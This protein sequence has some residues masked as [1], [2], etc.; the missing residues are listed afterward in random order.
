MAR[1]KNKINKNRMKK[2]NNQAKQV[3]AGLK[4]DMQQFM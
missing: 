1:L 3:L 4:H 2:R